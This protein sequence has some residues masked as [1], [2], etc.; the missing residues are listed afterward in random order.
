MIFDHRCRKDFQYGVQYCRSTLLMANNYN[1]SQVMAAGE[2]QTATWVPPPPPSTTLLHGTLRCKLHNEP[3]CIFTPTRRQL[4][5]IDLAPPPLRKPAKTTNTYLNSCRVAAISIGA[6]LLFHPSTFRICKVGN[7]ELD[8]TKQL[9]AFWHHRTK[10][11]GISIK[12]AKRTR[13]ATHLY[14][15]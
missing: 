10:L 9:K 14:V 2:L 1:L 15:V 4:L 6:K 5:Y 3:T 7:C 8:G 12:N 11:I 13:F